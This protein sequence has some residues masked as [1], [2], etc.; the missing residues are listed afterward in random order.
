MA[1]HRQIEQIIENDFFKGKIIVILGAR[2]VGKSTLIKILP[3]C[4]TIDT[5]WLDGENSDVRQIL[6]NANSERLKQLVG[7]YRI[8]VIDEAQKIEDIGSVLKLFADYNKDIQVIASGS[9]AFE[10]RNTLNE[11]LTG[12]K[13]EYKLFP[14]SFTE[15]VKHTNLLQ[16]IRELPQ[17]LVYGYYPEIVTSPNDAERL[18]RFLSDSYLYKDIFLFKGIK[19][20]EKML[21]LLKLLAFQIGSEVNFNE[22]SN[23]LKIDNQTVESYIEMLEQAFVI[24]KLPG[25][26]TN[27]RTE[28]KKSKKIYFND[29]GIR[30]A[31]INDFRPIEIRNDAGLLFENYV[32]NELRKQ[33]EYNR[34]YAN[35]YFWRN[36][37]QREIDLIIEKNG[38]IR[39]FE[40]KWNSAK[41]AKLTKGFTNI[42]GETEFKVINN[43]NFFEIIDN[44]T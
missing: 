43:E 2:Q 21:E 34:V 29:L 11:P 14:I 12:R 41:M 17:R 40:I 23:S 44:F 30:N 33:N 10:L 8:V 38:Q 25:Y 16:E 39:A 35:F 7:N 3:T 42:Y 18:L 22:L 1:I 9:S 5:L 20:P 19:K 6:K 28:L 26:H 15:M 36:T 32:V 4:N 27:Q 37:D 31:L 24:Y 13:F